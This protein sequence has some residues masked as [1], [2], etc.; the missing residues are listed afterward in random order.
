MRSFKDLVLHT[1]RHGAAADIFETLGDSLLAAQHLW[2]A[3]RSVTVD[4]EQLGVLGIE[5]NERLEVAPLDR[6]A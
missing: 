1:V 4:G 2:R 6:P 3:R 5:A